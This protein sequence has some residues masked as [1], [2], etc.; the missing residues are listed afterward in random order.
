MK[1]NFTLCND[2]E[3]HAVALE[4]RSCGDP[5]CPDRMAGRCPGRYVYAV[6]KASGSTRR[7]YAGK[8]IS[9]GEPCQR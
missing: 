4:L 7:D 6:Y 1:R 5:D 8:I 9:G 2:G 3:R